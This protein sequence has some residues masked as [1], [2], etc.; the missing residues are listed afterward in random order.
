MF[1]AEAGKKFEVMR[2]PFKFGKTE[3][4]KILSTQM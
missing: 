4:S 1:K 2:T 3:V